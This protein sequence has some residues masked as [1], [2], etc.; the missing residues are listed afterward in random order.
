MRGP[1]RK[2]LP[3]TILAGIG[4]GAAVAADLSTVPKHS[5]QESAG[6]RSAHIRRSLYVSN[7]STKGRARV[8]RKVEGP[9]LNLHFTEDYWTAAWSKSGSF[10]SHTFKVSTKT[11]SGHTLRYASIKALL[12]AMEADLRPRGEDSM[13]RRRII[14]YLF[15]GKPAFPRPAA[16]AFEHSWVRLTETIADASFGKNMGRPLRIRLDLL[17]QGTNV[18][19]KILHVGV[20]APNLL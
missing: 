7:H 11:S 20:V 17:A 14:L 2:F 1:A 5:Q 12:I 13:L 16:S 9:S 19:T 6:H 10:S 15:R 3:A 8:I 18:D 4:C